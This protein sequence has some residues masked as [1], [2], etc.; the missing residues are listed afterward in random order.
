[1]MKNEQFAKTKSSS[2]ETKRA[3]NAAQD[4]SLSL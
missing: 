1:M 2:Q 3:L 4:W